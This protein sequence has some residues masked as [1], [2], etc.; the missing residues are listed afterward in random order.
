LLLRAGSFGRFAQPAW[1]Q[2]GYRRSSEPNGASKG[3]AYRAQVTRTRC[4]AVFI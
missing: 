4:Q 2:N 1:A 3:R